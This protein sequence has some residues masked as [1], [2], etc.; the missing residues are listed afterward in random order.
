VTLRSLVDGWIWCLH[1]HG[2]PE[3]EA[4]TFVGNVGCGL[5]RRNPGME[6]VAVDYRDTQSRKVQNER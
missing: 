4:S 3:H 1:L 2:N 6:T 5:K